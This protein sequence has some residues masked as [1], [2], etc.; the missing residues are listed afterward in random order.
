MKN[1]ITRMITLLA[2]KSQMCI[3][4]VLSKYNLTAAEQP[5]FMA[6]QHN[7]GITQEELTAI[8]CVDKAATTRA[9]K[10]LEEKGYLIRKQDERDR[11]Q[12]RIYATMQAKQIS[13]MVRKEL[14]H[15]NDMV[16]QDIGLEEIDILYNALLKMDEN[17]TKIL[18]DIKNTQSSEK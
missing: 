17:F 14:L 2:R 11:R 12:N 7:E 16:T 13:G 1:K 18:T 15:L 5:F 3:G 4:N 6:L 9:V 8:V 10:S